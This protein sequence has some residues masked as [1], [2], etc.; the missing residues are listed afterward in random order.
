MKTCNRKACVLEASVAIAGLALVLLAF[1]LF[2]SSVGAAQL[3]EL[4]GIVAPTNVTELIYSPGHNSLVLKNSASAIMT[5]D[6]GTQS[7]TTHLSNWHFTDMS[8]SPSGNYV[9][10]ADY[11]GENIGYGTPENTSYVHRLDL[12]NNTWETNTKLHSKHY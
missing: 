2:T 10:A 9:F 11:G 7:S 4:E 5:I 6:L 3:S 8:M 1:P 12:S